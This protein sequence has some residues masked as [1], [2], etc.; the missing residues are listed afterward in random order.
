M[1]DNKRYY[2]D[3]VSFDKGVITV[4]KP[5]GQVGVYVQRG[6]HKLD[7][8]QFRTA[9]GVGMLRADAMN[10]AEFPR[11]FTLVNERPDIMGKVRVTFNINQL[12]KMLGK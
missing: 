4:V 10:F 2:V 1:V 6:V 7:M 8:M 5:D 12:A 11:E 9:V 3:L